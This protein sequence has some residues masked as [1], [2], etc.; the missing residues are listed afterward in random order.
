MKSSVTTR[1]GLLIGLSC[2]GWTFVMGLTGWYKHPTLL[3]A[4]WVVVFLEIGALVWALRRSAEQ[5]KGFGGL[6]AAGVTM[7]LLGAAI[8]FANSLVFTSLAFPRYFE[9]LRAV[10]TE[11]LRASG[12]PEA[13]IVAAV[14]AASQT[15]TPL[16][17]ATFGAIGTIMTGLV[18]SLAI[19]AI[20][21]RRAV[22]TVAVASPAAA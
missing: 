10:Q 21:R 1:G 18:A 13:E 15:Q 5:G 4:F 20:V 8:V 17:Q 14:A 22:P 11:L 2:A 6:V 3:N 9:E 7:S 16:L 12:T 19:A